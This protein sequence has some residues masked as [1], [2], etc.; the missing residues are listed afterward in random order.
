VLAAFDRAVMGAGASLDGA[1][2]KLAAAAHDLGGGVETFS[3]AIATLATELGALGRE[4]ALQAARGPEGDLGTVVLSEL[5]RIGAGLDR[6]VQLS[7]L[8]GGGSAF[9]SPTAAEL[10]AAPT[11]ESRSIDTE[12]THS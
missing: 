5:D 12:E 3:P 9:P 6:L 1:A 8:A 11:A 4:L 7:R 2:V 10:G